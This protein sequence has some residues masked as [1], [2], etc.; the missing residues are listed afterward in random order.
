MD[1]VRAA[2]PAAAQFQQSEHRVLGYA[3]G[4]VLFIVCLFYR[5]DVVQGMAASTCSAWC[6]SRGTLLGCDK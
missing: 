3:V 4:L 6:P 1:S 2:W 5:L